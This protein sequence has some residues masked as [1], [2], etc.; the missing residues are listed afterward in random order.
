MFKIIVLL[1]EAVFSNNIASNLTM[2]G[3]LQISFQ[4]YLLALGYSEDGTPA[5]NTVN[6]TLCKFMYN[7]ANSGGGVNIFS[8]KIPSLDTHSAV[9]FS[10]CSWT[11]NT[12]L[13]YGAA[14]HI[15]PGVWA[16]VYE[17]HYLRLRFSN[18][19]ISSNK[20]D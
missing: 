18:C 17:G 15:M 10:D 5:N 6:L 11:G 7:D 2:G 19:N 12:A 13:L 4:F 3:G 1:V 14:V 20:V 9:Y 8:I 16:S